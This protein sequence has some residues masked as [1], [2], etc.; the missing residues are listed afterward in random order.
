MSL[1]TFTENFGTAFKTRVA[2]QTNTAF[3][4][5]V[6]DSVQ[7]VPGKIYNSE[8]NLIVRGVIGGGNVAGLADYGTRLKASFSNIPA[9]VQLFVSTV[10]VNNF[11]LP[12][13][14]VGSLRCV[15]AQHRLDHS[16]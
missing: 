11:A 4:G 9:G 1:L 15:L 2:A 8:S 10:N 13:T 5:Q 12:V 14:P 16:S 6:N 3:A 7:N